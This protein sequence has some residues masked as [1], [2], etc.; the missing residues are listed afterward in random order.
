MLYLKGA[1]AALVLAL[2]GVLGV[3]TAQSDTQIIR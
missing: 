2:A 3:A 1:A